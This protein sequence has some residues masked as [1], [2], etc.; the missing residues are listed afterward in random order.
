MVLNEQKIME[1]LEEEL[2]VEVDEL[3]GDTELFSSGLID[4]FSMV[5]LMAFL[6]D[7]EGIQMSSM[8]VN[9][10]NLDTVNRMLAY[11]QKAT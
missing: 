7:S 9:L 5:S 1:F 4:S 11:L 6:E 10:N 8:D 3:N 2:D